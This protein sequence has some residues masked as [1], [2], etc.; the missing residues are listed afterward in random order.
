MAAL[1][2]L[3]ETARSGPD[4]AALAA[5]LPER[6]RRVTTT[7]AICWTAAAAI[8]ALWNVVVPPRTLDLVRRSNSGAW[9]IA[10]LFLSA[11]CA[12]LLAWVCAAGNGHAAWRRRAWLAAG[13]AL[14]FLSLDAVAGLQTQE[15][16]RL[17]NRWAYEAGVISSG[18]IDG[19]ELPPVTAPLTAV[20]GLLLVA[21]VVALSDQP[22]AGAF[23]ILAL[24]ALALAGMLQ[25]RLLDLHRA[26][27]SPNLLAA[28]DIA[29]LGGGA[30]LLWAFTL[31]LRAQ[32]RC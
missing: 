15:L 8:V 3:D 4:G 21:G 11:A 6:L 12:A 2:H 32:L 26:P 19:D 27:P 23:G 30:L 5:R 1:S 14:L 25:L 7:A 16:P 20:A 22:K 31:R 13:A 24:A 9:L 28:I 29:R 18:A 10:A 17:V